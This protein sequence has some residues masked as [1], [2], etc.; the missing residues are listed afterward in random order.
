MGKMNRMSMKRIITDILN[1]TKDPIDDIYISY[2]EADIS[3]IKALVV[4]PRDTPY[5]GGFYMFKIKFPKDYPHKPPHVDFLTTDRY[6]R[7]NPNLYQCGKVCLSIL[8][9]WSGPSWTSVMN[10][11]SVLLSLQSLLQEYPIR[12]E[13]GYETTTESN[14]G[15]INYNKIVHWYN[16][17]Y[18][19]LEMSKKPQV[20]EFSTKINEIMN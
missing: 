12:N 9:T 16:W 8:G 1:I 4:G 17:Y 20:A 15:S 5:E 10:L 11:R 7:F 3:V 6:I 19:V 13:P 14:R 18:A 2:S